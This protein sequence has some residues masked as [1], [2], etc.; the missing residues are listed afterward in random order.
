MDSAETYMPLLEDDG[1]LQ[2]GHRQPVLDLLDLPVDG[3]RL[4]FLDVDDAAELLDHEF[5]ALV[6][7]P[8]DA[9]VEQLPV[10]DER[11]VLPPGVAVT[12]DEAD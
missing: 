10:L 7:E 6:V 5:L 9:L 3:H 11:Y 8:R 4:E 12:H 1:V 2:V